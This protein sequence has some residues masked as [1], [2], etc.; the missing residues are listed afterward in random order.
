MLPWQAGSVHAT[1]HRSLSSPLTRPVSQLQVPCSPLPTSLSPSPLLPAQALERQKE[2][3]DSI[4]S[5]RDDLRQEAVAL[6]E[7]L[8]VW[9]RRPGGA[10]AEAAQV[11]GLPA[12]T[13]SW[14]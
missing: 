9:S 7:E 12:R 8:K 4:R 14:R 5:E 3:F 2:F 10:A 11:R 1:S 13:A 6:K